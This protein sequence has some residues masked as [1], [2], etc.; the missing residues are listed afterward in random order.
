M[1]LCEN[2]QMTELSN[3]DIYSSLCGVDPDAN[4][5]NELNAHISQH[6]NYY[7]GHSFSTIIQTMFK[8]MIDH[9]VFSSSHINIRS[10]KANLTSFD[11]FLQNLEFEFSVIGITETLLTDSN[12]DLYNINGF[13]FVETCWNFLEKYTIS[14]TIWPS[15]KQWV[16]WIIFIEIDKDLFNKIRYIIIGVIYRPSNTD[17]TIFNDD[18]NELLD[19]LEREHKYGYLM[20]TIKL[21]C[22]IIANMRK[23]P[24]SLTYNVCPF[25]SVTYE[26]SH[27]SSQRI[28]YINR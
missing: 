5:F 4:Y 20:G 12:C 6:C 8:N 21:T 10:M 1:T 25:F 9:N 27:Q 19:I 11:I 16:Q 22:L 28:C 18:I 13:N 3:D 17:L 26:P 7:H 15:F 24:L 23:L 14:N 2:V